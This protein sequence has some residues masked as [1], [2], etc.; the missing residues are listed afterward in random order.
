MYKKSRAGIVIKTLCKH[1]GTLTR[2][3]KKEKPLQASAM[4]KNVVIGFIGGHGLTLHN[5][6][7]PYSRSFCIIMCQHLP[8]SLARAQFGLRVSPRPGYN[9]ITERSIFFW[10]TCFTDESAHSNH[11]TMT[12]TNVA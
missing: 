7:W 5:K 12:I 2:E 11:V 6:G 8:S 3:Y 10:D 9:V 4:H 1:V